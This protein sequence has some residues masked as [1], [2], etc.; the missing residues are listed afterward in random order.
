MKN[1]ITI[2]KKH[3][4][5]GLAFILALVLVFSFMPLTVSADETPVHELLIESELPIDHGMI[6]VN[7][8]AKGNWEN[9]EHFTS[10]NLTPSGAVRYVHEGER[11]HVAVEPEPGYI[12]YSCYARY[13][14][15][16]HW[17]ALDNGYALANDHGTDFIFEVPSGEGD[18]FIEVGA[19]FKYQ[20]FEVRV[21]DTAHGT[22][23][24]DY[25]RNGNPNSYGRFFP[26]NRAAAGDTITINAIPEEGYELTSLIVLE[27]GIYDRITV[28]NNQFRMP[29]NFVTVEA[30]FTEI[31]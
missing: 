20:P 5:N 28:T 9:F 30:V 7:I 18:Y 24:V 31:A 19:S 8:G 12:I 15:H 13:Y 4:R 25:T 22:I 1:L 16:G 6:S 27:H 11:I 29:R 26:E 23:T 3:I 17:I 2:N 21:K 14:A 10:A